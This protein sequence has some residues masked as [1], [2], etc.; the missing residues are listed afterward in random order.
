MGP[1]HL[2]VGS[3]AMI[4]DVRF[5]AGKEIV[6]AWDHGARF[7]VDKASAAHRVESKR[8]SAK[9]AHGAL[10]SANSSGA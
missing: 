4:A 5:S 8:L 6:A 3:R 7:T 1:A 2:T 9:S 10:H